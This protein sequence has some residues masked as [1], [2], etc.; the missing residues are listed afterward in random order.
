M[1][2]YSIQ[3]KPCQVIAEGCSYQLQRY[4]NN[5]KKQMILQEN[6]KTIGIKA[7]LDFTLHSSP[8]R[9]EPLCLSALREVKSGPSLFTTLHNPSP[10]QRPDVQFFI[11]GEQNIALA[12]AIFCPDQAQNETS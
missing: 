7:T 12:V 9:R 3:Q 8:N 2:S 11:S 4:K 10:E 1:K 6:R 5:L